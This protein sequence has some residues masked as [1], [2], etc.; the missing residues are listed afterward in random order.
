MAGGQCF[1][2]FHFEIRDLGADVGIGNTAPTKYPECPNRIVG[3]GFPVPPIF[4]EHFVR[5]AGRVTRPLRIGS[6]FRGDVGDGVLDV[7]S[8]L[9]NQTKT[10]TPSIFR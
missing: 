5:Y 3:D 6:Q 2:L 1:L 10:E 8:F 7:P 4:P 9:Y